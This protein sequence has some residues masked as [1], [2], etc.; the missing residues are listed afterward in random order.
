MLLV[1]GPNQP[2]SF[3]AKLRW[4]CRVCSWHCSPFRALFSLL[5]SPRNRRKST[6]MPDGQKYEDWLKD[7]EDRKENE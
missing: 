6:T 7:R 2:D 3:S 1:G 4:V 5:N